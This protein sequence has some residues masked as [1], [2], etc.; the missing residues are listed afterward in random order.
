M[1]K[2]KHITV[3]CRELYEE[4]SASAV[5]D[6]ANKNLMNR[7]DVAYKH[8]KGCDAETPHWNNTC[9]ICEQINE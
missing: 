8:C 1:R 2:L 7:H 6:Y 5:Y 4:K 3:I 9:L